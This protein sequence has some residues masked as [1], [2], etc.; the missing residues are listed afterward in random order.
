MRYVLTGLLGAALL[1]GCG[2]DDGDDDKP[3]TD[4][5]VT[6]SGVKDAGAK[7]AGGGSIDASIDSGIKDSG[8][9]ANDASSTD[10]AVATSAKATLEST[11]GNT[12]TGVATFA[13][14]SGL[15][16][17]TLTIKGATPGKH[18]THIHVMPDCGMN[19]ANAGGHWNPDMHNHGSAAADAGALS[20]LG[21][22]GNITIDSAG[23]GELKVSKAEWTLGDGALTDVVGHAV[24]FHANEDDLITNMGD[25]GPGNSGGRLACG[26]IAK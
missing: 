17:L 9:I 12:V 22:L 13:K 2:D 14:A 23:A 25:A 5:A 20:H 15:V 3:T 7:D 4:A 24:V 16:T 19:A 21:D 18:G 10:A 6:D 1:F 26:V 8:V 11:T